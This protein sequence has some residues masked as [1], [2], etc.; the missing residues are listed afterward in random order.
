MPTVNSPDISTL[1][2]KVTLDISGVNPVISLVNQ[3]AGAN[4]SALIW[5]LNVYSPTGTPIYNTSFDAPFK[6]GV[7]SNASVTNPWPKPYGRIEFN[8]NYI[9]E[10]SVRDSVGNVFVLNKQGELR[11]PVGNIAKKSTD[12]YG[13]VNLHI[14]V[15]CER[16]QIYFLDK[17]SKSY[18]GRI[19]VMISSYLAL[20]Y[21]RDPTDVL[22]PAFTITSFNGDAL[23]PFSYNGEG[24]RVSYHTIYEYDLGNNVF[25]RIRYVAQK[26]F[27]VQCNI[28]LCPLYCEVDRLTS[29][30]DTGNCAD[31]Q[32]A[33]EKLALIAPKLALIA[34]IKNRPDCGVDINKL[35]E[36][37][38]TI[39]GFSCDCSSATTGIGAQSALVDGVAFN[40][41]SEGGDIQGRFENVGNNIVLYLN[42]KTY[43]FEICDDSQSEAFEFRTN[44]TGSVTSTCFFVDRTLL[45][46]EILNTIK[47]D[48]NLTN[49]FNS[50]VNTNG[51][52][53]LITVDGKCVM[54]T[55]P[56]TGYTWTIANVPGSP[57]SASLV[58]L[59]VN[60]VNNIFSFAFNTTNL[61]ALQTYL[62][63]KG[64]GT[65][66]VQAG[67]SGQ[68]NITSD[69]NPNTISDLVYNVGA[70]N[71]IAVQTNIATSVG[72]FTPSEI[73]QAIIN[74]LCGITDSE[75]NLSQPF[76]VPSIGAGEKTNTLVT[77]V[78]NEDGDSQ[79]LTDLLQAFI[80]SQNNVIDYVLSLKGADCDAMKTI[81]ANA[82]SPISGTTALYG[83]VG[84]TC[85]QVNPL[86]LFQ[87][88]I[89]NMDT[90]TR[91]LFCEAVVACGAGLACEPYNSFYVEVT[92]YDTT[93]SAIVGIEGVFS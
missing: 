60:G 18:Q 13:Q 61:T 43:Q 34:L 24:Y 91:E 63:G 30:I 86:A 2:V 70:G 36:E 28:D 5:A 88:Q 11:P 82:T 9:V 83:L 84:D 46:E 29:D 48:V 80:S 26:S 7:W 58:S 45:S 15:M 71:V 77:P 27:N 54:T 20:D 53:F 12:T 32:A 8:G 37:V 35:I 90:V 1:E 17:T 49:L 19:G 39:G 31:V 21:P 65:F 62:N 72:L 68:I 79:T 55:N 81:F 40:V 38:K 74:Y 42:D 50:I 69:N 78:P 92:P 4:L 67:A 44:T 6:T 47:G 25:A 76:T 16:A 64:F 22:P 66:S 75:I 59:K 87:Y 51:E 33:K 85:G 3:S 93:C 52:G 10:L 89:K 56:L 41:V 73:V 57:Q 23:V 14:E